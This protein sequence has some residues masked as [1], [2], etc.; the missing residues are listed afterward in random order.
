MIITI[1]N[2]KGGVGKSTLAWHIVTA[3]CQKKIDFIVVDLDHQR[4]IFN[5]NEYIRETNKMKCYSID[6]LSQLDNIIQTNQDKLI[7]IDTAGQ[8]DS[9]TKHAM[10]RANKILT[11][12]GNDSITEAIGFKKFEAIL[13]ELNNPPINIVFSNIHHSSNNF[14]DITEVVNEYE[15][16]T[17]LDTIVRHRNN[18]K[19]TMGQGLGVSELQTTKNQTQNNLLKKSIDEIS[20]L[21]KELE[22]LGDEKV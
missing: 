10:Q 6:T 18:Y 11:P 5:L 13:S 16:T 9:L 8:G 22:I 2:V 19:K 4:T 12:I 7:V 17:I 20:S 1:S 3:L 21:L 15:N 14:S